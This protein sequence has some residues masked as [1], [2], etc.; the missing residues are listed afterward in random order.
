MW[1]GF[2]EDMGIREGR[3][4]QPRS[5][6][7][8]GGPELAKAGHTLSGTLSLSFVFDLVSSAST[9]CWETSQTDGLSL[10]PAIHWEHV[11]QA[12]NKEPWV[13]HFYYLLTNDWPTGLSIS[14]SRIN[15]TSVWWNLPVTFLTHHPPQ[16]SYYWGCSQVPSPALSKPTGS[17]NSHSS[18]GRQGVLR[19][20]FY[21][22]GDRLSEVKQQ[23]RRLES[24][25]VCTKT[26]YT[27][28]GEHKCYPKRS[29]DSSYWLQQ[30]MTASR[31][32]QIWKATC[33]FGGGIQGFSVTVTTVSLKP[34]PLWFS[35]SPTRWPTGRPVPCQ[36]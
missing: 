31:S 27:A 16:P 10:Y 3:G 32:S 19:S 30:V 8:D 26:C 34:S 35:K 6:G 36:A 20:P 13:L 25:A 2:W 17:L 5:W 29:K 14:T 33:R 12:S 7:P 28:S 9:Y 1:S 22:W 21:T 4:P 23:Q 11:C 15:C 24:R 18:P